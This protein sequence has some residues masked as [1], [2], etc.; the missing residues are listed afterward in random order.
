MKHELK[1]G[2]T[3]RVRSL[4]YTYEDLKLEQVYTGANYDELFKIYLWGFETE[5]DNGLQWF[6]NPFK[7]YL[8]GFETL[9]R[10]FGTDEIEGLRYTYEDL[11]HHNIPPS[12]LA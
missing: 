9:D 8:W 7:I 12:K 11:K 1:I 10:F 3:I 2:D 5:V 4:R 6:S